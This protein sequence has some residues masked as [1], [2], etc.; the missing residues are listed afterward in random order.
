MSVFGSI[1]NPL[2]RAWW[3]L[4]E[5]P[6]TEENLLRLCEDD[7]LVH[8]YLRHRHERPITIEEAAAVLILWRASRET[9]MNLLEDHITVEELWMGVLSA[10]IDDRYWDGSLL[11]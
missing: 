10:M 11:R 3:R 6:P 5:G 8:A 4:T 1:K 9:E 7:D 2:A